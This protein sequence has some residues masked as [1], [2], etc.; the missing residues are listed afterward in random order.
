MN[1]AFHA[2]RSLTVRRS[3]CRD[4]FRENLPFAVAI[5]AAPAAGPRLHPITFRQ[6]VKAQ[7]S[8]QASAVQAE[9]FSPFR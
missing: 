1:D 3:Y 8:I 4:P 5:S 7:P 9:L 6:G 2:L